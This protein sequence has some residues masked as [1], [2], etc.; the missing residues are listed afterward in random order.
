VPKLR[1]IPNPGPLIDREVLWHDPKR[2]H[3]DVALRCTPAIAAII[4]VGVLLDQSQAAAI[5]CGGA[6]TVGGGVYQ[7]I[8]QSQIAP[9][10]LATLGMGLSAAIG[11]VAG[12]APLPMVLSVILWGFVAGLLP[13]LDSGGQWIGQQCA[14]ALMVAASFPGTLDHALSR[15]GLVMGG[16]ILQIVTIETT[17]RFTD[18]TV[19]LKGWPE[20]ITEAQAAWRTLQTAV[21][22]QSTALHFAIRVALML[23]AAVMTERMLSLPNGYWVGMTTLL[24]LRQAFHDT[25]HRSASRIGGTLAGAALA[26]LA[27]W[28]GAPAWAF[29]LAIPVTA[30]CCFALQQYSYAIFSACLTCYIVL[31]LT[32]AGLQ[33]PL[34]AHNRI[35]GTLIG[36]GFA[37]AGHLHFLAWRIQTQPRA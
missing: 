3:L 4:L 30:F 34:V 7:R 5:M 25:W 11:T 24:L 31:L 22:W 19:E 27:A 35:V 1:L 16:G 8:G 21:T 29:A 12:L 28:A 13:V 10:L 23:G 9:M 14:I 15:A 18:L 20:T 36:A 37:L 32:Y 2:I 26:S 17:L 33:A 6:L